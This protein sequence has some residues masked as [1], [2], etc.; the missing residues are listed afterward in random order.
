ML[1]IRLLKQIILLFLFFDITSLPCYALT[2]IAYGGD[3]GPQKIFFFYFRDHSCFGASHSSSF[4]D[5]KD[6]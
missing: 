2:I 5:K 4:A 1:P 3:N 6:M